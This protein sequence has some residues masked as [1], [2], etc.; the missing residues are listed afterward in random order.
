M[1]RKLSALGFIVVAILAILLFAY[2]R[3]SNPYH[4]NQSAKTHQSAGASVAQPHPELSPQSSGSAKNLLQPTSE[5]DGDNSL[6][7]QTY[8]NK[9][10]GFKFAY[11][12]SATLTMMPG[13]LDEHNT[14]RLEAIK[15]EFIQQADPLV[16]NFEDTFEFSVTVYSNP[17]QLT[18]RQ[19]ALKQWDT[20]VIREQQGI[21]L[22][23]VPAY[24]LRNFE[25]DQDSDY[26]Y[27]A[28]GS[29]MYHLSYWDPQTMYDFAS[30]IRER[31]TQ[32]FDRI[33]RSFAIE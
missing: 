28:K 1:A 31:Y 21:V 30:Q 4:S 7:W 18:A 15:I 2:A 16:G 5:A 9:I 17:E 20:D 32:T 23:G 22:N 19:W 13:G 24:K 3:F 14:A 27:L 33:A 25:T 29:R 12:M 6:N 11:P 26:I 8:T 10:Y